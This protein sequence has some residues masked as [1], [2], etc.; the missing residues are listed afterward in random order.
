MPWHL[1][2]SLLAV[3]LLTFTLICRGPNWFGKVRLP[4]SSLSLSLTLS[5]LCLSTPLCLCVE[6]NCSAI[7]KAHTPSP[8]PP[9]SLSVCLGVWVGPNWV[10][11][12]RLSL[13]ASV[14][15][16]VSHPAD[17]KLKAAPPINTCQIHP[18]HKS[19]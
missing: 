11:Q 8:S 3:W 7:G 5:P 10:G 18:S 2:L 12:V 6:P 9:L 1:G 19:A 14:P 4:I 13:L 15:P 17:V 16:T